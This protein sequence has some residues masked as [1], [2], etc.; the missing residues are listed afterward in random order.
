MRTFAQKPKT[1]QPS[2]SAKT[3]IVSRAHVR[4]GHDPSSILKVQRTIENQALLRLLQNSAAEGDAVLIGT[5][6]PHFGHDFARIPANP[7]KASALQ[8]KLAINKSADEYEQEAD[9]IAEQVMRMPERQIQ[10]AC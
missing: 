9:R 4:Q 2:T 3:S 7:P 6:S 5:A 1:T 8:T 10:R